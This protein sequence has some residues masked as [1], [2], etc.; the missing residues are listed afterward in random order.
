MQQNH[1]WVENHK[2]EPC[3]HKHSVTILNEY[4]LLC[5]ICHARIDIMHHLPSAFSERVSICLLSYYL[6]TCYIVQKLFN[7]FSPI[8]IDHLL[9]DVTFTR[10]LFMISPCNHIRSRVA[11]CYDQVVCIQ[12]QKPVTKVVKLHTKR[13]GF[14]IRNVLWEFLVIFSIYLPLVLGVYKAV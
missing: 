1:F 9:T 6:F 10:Q 14:V 2:F 5:P 3:G 7:C 8:N 4:A 13:V 12:C 11:Y